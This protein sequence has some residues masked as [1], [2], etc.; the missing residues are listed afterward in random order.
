[1]TSA[2]RRQIF[3]NFKGSEFLWPRLRQLSSAHF[4]FGLIN[5]REHGH[6]QIGV[7]FAMKHIFLPIRFFPR[8]QLRETMTANP[9]RSLFR[10]TVSAK[11]R[12][13]GLTAV[14]ARLVVSR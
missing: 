11:R 10:S 13:R 14:T 2:C 3:L 9:D 5:S 8:R 7:G 1:M 4:C 12:A 6:R